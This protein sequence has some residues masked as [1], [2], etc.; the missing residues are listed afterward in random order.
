MHERA[1]VPLLHIR[2]PLRFARNSTGLDMASDLAELG[3][4]QEARSDVEREEKL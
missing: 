2:K 3:T 1:A 4:V